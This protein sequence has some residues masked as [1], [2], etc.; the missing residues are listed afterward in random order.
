[1]DPFLLSFIMSG[2]SCPLVA[3]DCGAPC[4]AEPWPGQQTT[5]GPFCRWSSSCCEPAQWPGPGSCP[6]LSPATQCQQQK[7]LPKVCSPTELMLKTVGN[8]WKLVTFLPERLEDSDIGDWV[9]L[10]NTS[11]GSSAVSDCVDRFLCSDC[12]ADGSLTL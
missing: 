3:A 5:S 1:M 10:K 7:Q 2:V 11:V 6:G 4:A 12:G 9:L 8:S